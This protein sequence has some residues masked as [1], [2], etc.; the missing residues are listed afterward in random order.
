ME[1]DQRFDGI[2]VLHALR[3]MVYALPLQKVIKLLQQSSALKFSELQN[4][5]VPVFI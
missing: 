1:H 3:S 2:L 4:C 5:Y